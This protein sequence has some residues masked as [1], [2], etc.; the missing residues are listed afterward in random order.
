VAVTAL[1]VLTVVS[2]AGA[3]LAVVNGLGPL[4][5]ER[6]AAAD[7]FP[8]APAATVTFTPNAGIGGAGP[9]RVAPTTTATTAVVSPVTAVVPRA[10]LGKVSPIRTPKPTN[11]ECACGVGQPP[12]PT[13]TA[14]SGSPSPTGE[15]QSPEPSD[16]TSAEPSADPSATSPSP[17][18]SAEPS[19][20]PQDR[21][22]RRR[23]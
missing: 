12:V 14:P 21:H 6:Q 8:P 4:L 7:T 17:S 9:R 1:G 11:P 18:A 2:A 16:S 5:Q 13:P 15:P 23:H 10:T 19:E 20:N 3:Y 22:N